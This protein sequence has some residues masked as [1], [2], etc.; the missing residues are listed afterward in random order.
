MIGDLENKEQ[1]MSTCR[2]CGQ[3]K[4]R[5]TCGQYLSKNKRFVDENGKQWCG[6]KCPDCHRSIQKSRQIDRRSK[7]KEHLDG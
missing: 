6:R 5:I 2:V 3:I 1:D 7:K 4:K